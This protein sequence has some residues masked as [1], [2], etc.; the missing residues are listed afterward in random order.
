MLIDLAQK[1]QM[2]L[3]LANKVN[4]SKEYTNFSDIFS[5]KSAT[6][7][8]NFLNINKHTINLKSDK[9]PS[10]KLI[11]SLS[12]IELEIFKTYMKTNLTNGFIQPSNSFAKAHIFFF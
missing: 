11:Y 6:V 1:A 8:P 9:Q 3:L 4:I 7:L 2:S 12:L 5:K 10:Y